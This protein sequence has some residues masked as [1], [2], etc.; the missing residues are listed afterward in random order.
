MLSVFPCI[1]LAVFNLDENDVQLWKAWRRGDN[2]AF[3]PLFERYSLRFERLAR[4]ILKNDDDARDVVMEVFTDFLKKSL[5]ERKKLRLKGRVVDYLQKAVKNKALKVLDA[6]KKKRPLHLVPEFID[7][8]PPM[9][10][11]WE[12]ID[13]LKAGDEQV[14]WDDIQQIAGLTEFEYKVWRLRQKKQSYAEISQ[15]TGGNPGANATLHAKAKKKMEAHKVEILAYLTRI[16][17]E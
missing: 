4:A 7:A 5:A 11:I 3:G 15:Q 16:I 8:S 2:A 12:Y 6:Q 9:Q 14:L 1:I 13:Q 17:H 10:S